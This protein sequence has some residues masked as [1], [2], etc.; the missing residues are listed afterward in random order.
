MPKGINRG[1][2]Y[3]LV[4]PYNESPPVATGLWDD[5]PHHPLPTPQA[6]YAHP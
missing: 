5:A 6:I 3:P 1:G 4:L 2:A